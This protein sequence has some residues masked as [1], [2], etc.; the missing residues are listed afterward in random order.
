MYSKSFLA[1]LCLAASAIAQAGGAES[2]P[3][4]Q[5]L[6]TASEDEAETILREVDARIYRPRDHGLK[7]LQCV[8][9]CKG[10]GALAS[11]DFM[12][13]FAWR[14]PY[15]ERIEVLTA[16]GKP[17]TEVPKLLREQKPNYIAEQVEGMK[18]LVYTRVIG[19]R[20]AD[21]YADYY[22]KVSKREVNNKIETRIEMTPRK[23]KL[24]SKIVLKLRDGLPYEEIKSRDSGVDLHILHN[25]AKEGELF[26]PKL[27]HSEVENRLMTEEELYYVAV[28][29]ILLATSLERRSAQDGIKGVQKVVLEDV[30]AN[31][32]LPD[33]MF[34]APEKPGEVK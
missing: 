14:A 30:Q 17:M 7:D 23:K 10:D 2:R 27:F 12:I 13:K 24:F 20:L 9:R 22:K 11:V 1:V 5:P 19:L 6:V 8:W 28:D 29:G 26:L 4:S 16:D 34:K 3:T 25:Y 18:A 31:K 32:G 15:A 33:S 21:V